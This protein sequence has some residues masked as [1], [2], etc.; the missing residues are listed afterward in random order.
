MLQCWHQKQSFEE[1]ATKSDVSAALFWGGVGEVRGWAGLD[2]C[3]SEGQLYKSR[4][5]LLSVAFSL[6]LWPWELGSG[7]VSLATK[8]ITVVRPGGSFR[9]PRV[10]LPWRKRPWK[11][12]L[13]I[14][15]LLTRSSS[16]PAGQLSNTCLAMSVAESFGE[17][18]KSCIFPLTR[19]R[20]RCTKSWSLWLV[21]AEDGGR[22]RAD[23]AG[24][25]LQLLQRARALHLITVVKT[26]IQLNWQPSSC[27]VLGVKHRN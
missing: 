4:Q 2:V 25:E 11:I 22:S 5:Q 10:T 20:R 15:G 3:R 9:A 24:L 27:R 8:C 23:R 16:H 6:F 14:L 13:N 12:S 26:V 19:I 18:V 1:S 21:M 17:K 7:R